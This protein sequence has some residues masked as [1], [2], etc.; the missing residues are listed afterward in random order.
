M[1][2]LNARQLNAYWT[3]GWALVKHVV[4]R[5]FIGRRVPDRWL[6]RLRD[7]SLGAVPAHAWEAFEGSSRCIACGV[8]E[9]AGAPGDQPMRW[10]LSIAR[11]PG[12]APLVGHEVERLAELASDIERVCP[13]RVPV[14]ELVALVRANESMLEER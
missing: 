5:P 7:E 6:A 10:V 4:A 2:L 8:C 14:R 3:L 9:V 1:S 13:A 11:Q 12:D